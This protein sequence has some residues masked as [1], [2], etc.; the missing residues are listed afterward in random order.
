MVYFENGRIM[1]VRNEDIL[2]E[3]DSTLKK[4]GVSPDKIRKNLDWTLH[5]S[6]QQI[7]QRAIQVAKEGSERD[8]AFLEVYDAA[9]AASYGARQ[10]NPEALIALAQTVQ[11]LKDQQSVSPPRIIGGVAPRPGSLHSPTAREILEQGNEPRPRTPYF[12]NTDQGPRQIDPNEPYIDFSHDIP[13]TVD[14]RK[15][16]YH[17]PTQ[18]G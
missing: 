18:G 10:G 14:P 1:F 8:R 15:P 4:Q 7:A 16:P 9:I 6:T 17:N 5:A 13:Q 2:K 3:A 12:Q 11:K